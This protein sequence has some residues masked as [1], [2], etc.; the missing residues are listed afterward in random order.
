MK[1]K[2]LCNGEALML[3]ADILHNVLLSRGRCRKSEFSDEKCEKNDKRFESAFKRLC[4]GVDFRAKN[5]DRVLRCKIATVA[6]PDGSNRVW[7]NIV[8]PASK[9]SKKR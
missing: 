4:R 1:R 6:L 7:V 2:F 9:K 5:A 3:L 8:P